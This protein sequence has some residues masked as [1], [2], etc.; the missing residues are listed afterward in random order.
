M[1]EFSSRS[2]TANAVS[3]IVPVLNGGETFALC[4]GALGALSPQPGEFLVA[5][6][7]STDGSA[8]RAREFGAQVYRTARPRSGPA[9]ARNLAAHHAR[10]DILFF[11]DSDVLVKP[12]TIARIGDIFRTE[13]SL[14]ALYGSYDDCPPARNF[15]SQYKN[16]FHHFVHQESTG[17]ATSFWAGCGAIRREV[18]V[19]L[20]EFSSEFTRPS[21]EDI[22]FGYRLKKAGCRSRLVKD[23]QVTHLKKWTFRSLLESDIRDRALPWTRLILRERELPPDLNLKP[24]H[25]LSV[26]LVYLF[27]FSLLSVFHFPFSR[28]TLLVCAVT[29]LALNSRL[30]VFFASRRGV[31]FTLAAIPLH[32]FYYFYSGLAFAIGVILT[33][34][35][36]GMNLWKQRLDH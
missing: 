7:G 6:D 10:G 8:E 9:L 34:F 14:S 17:E 22:E 12:D 18:F 30:Y 15:V 25:R 31:I 20:G 33:A 19:R 5:D 13:I 4:L 23:L 29:L 36:P 11:V 35:E 26:V 21:I 1:D 28:Y 16:L 2:L 24:T 27:I 32:W 3:L